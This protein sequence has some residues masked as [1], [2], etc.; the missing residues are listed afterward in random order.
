MRI[1][2]TE[3]AAEKIAE[4]FAAHQLPPGACLRVGVRG[5]GCAGLSYTL[6]AAD[7]PHDGDEVFESHG[8]RLAA[9]PRAAPYL[10]G[11]ETDFDAQWAVGGFVFRN[12]NARRACGC[13]SSFNV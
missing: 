9:D 11:T 13:G 1:T 2:L 8:V 5:G 3:R 6:D 10:D 7:A 4:L 12:P